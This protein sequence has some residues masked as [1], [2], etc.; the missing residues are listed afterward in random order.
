MGSDGLWWIIKDN[1]AFWVYMDTGYRHCNKSTRGVKSGSATWLQHNG[2]VTRFMVAY[3]TVTCD[4]DTRFYPYDKHVCYFDYISKTYI[5]TEITLKHKPATI[6][7]KNENFEWEIKKIDSNIIHYSTYAYDIY[8]ESVRISLHI[9]R[10]PQFEL[11]NQ[12]LPLVMLYMLT[13]AVFYIP[14][15]SG[16]RL[17]FSITLFLTFTMAITSSVD[18]L[19]RDAI[20]ITMMSYA[21]IVISAANSVGVVWNILVV[22]KTHQVGKDEVPPAFLRK[23]LRRVRSK[24][25]SCRTKKTKVTI[26]STKTVKN[27]NQTLC[28]DGVEA[29]NDT[30]NVHIQHKCGPPANDCYT[31]H[32]VMGFLDHVMFFVML[33]VGLCVACAIWYVAHQG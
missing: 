4:I 10:R 7:M 3:T 21:T 18:R 29:L 33:I 23:L 24:R 27:R 26:I 9:S 31:W 12:Y 2:L 11:L 5:P 32:D 16:E 19:P 1:H 14:P 25:C 6:S 8:P 20:H 22:R 30:N 13:L 28:Q 15:D 17:S